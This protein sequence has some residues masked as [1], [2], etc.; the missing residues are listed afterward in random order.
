MYVT[1]FT[2]VLS[3]SNTGIYLSK[4]WATI[5]IGSSAAAF[6]YRLNNH[7]SHFAS[8]A[9]LFKAVIEMYTSSRMVMNV[10]SF[11]KR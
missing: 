10:H 9:R 2:V 4:G 3:R 5:L 6:E 7:I 1:K 11:G 8:V